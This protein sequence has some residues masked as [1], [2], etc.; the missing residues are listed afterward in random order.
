VAKV[1][2]NIKEEQKPV[3]PWGLGDT[4]PESD[5]RGV[6]E[7]CPR[8]LM[9][10]K[11]RPH[12]TITLTGKDAALV[13][14]EDGTLNPLVRSSTQDTV[15]EDVV[16]LIAFARRIHDQDVRDLL[17]DSGAGRAD[18]ACLFRADFAANARQ[19]AA[20]ESLALRGFSLT[21]R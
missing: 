18:K 12:A 16:L 5:A 8:S 10:H 17:A 6:R 7:I 4:A 3:T 14:E 11:P 20:A 13:I 2:T 15:S 1:P 19:K 21:R 9:P